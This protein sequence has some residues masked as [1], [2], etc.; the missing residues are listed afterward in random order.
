MEYDRIGGIAAHWTPVLEDLDFGRFSPGPPSLHSE[1]MSTSAAYGHPYGPID[2]D[3][4]H[5][6]SEDLPTTSH[7]ASSRTNTDAAVAK[8]FGQLAGDTDFQHDSP[9]SDIDWVRRRR[10]NSHTQQPETIYSSQ[11]YAWEG[12]QYSAHIAEVGAAIPGT[13]SGRVSKDQVLGSESHPWQSKEALTMNPHEID[14]FDNFVLRISHWLDLFDPMQSFSTHVPHLAMHN[15]GLLNAILSL[16]TCHL[17]LTSRHVNKISLNR[18]D[19]VQYY[20]ETLRYIQDA[21]KH[22]SYNRS[23]ELLSTCLIISAYEMID[24]SHKNW[25]RHLQG[26]YRLQQSPLIHG[27]SRGIKQAVWWAWLCQDIWA[28][29]REKRRPYTSWHPTQDYDNMTPYEL[30]ACSIYLMGQVVSYC[31]QSEIDQGERNFKRRVATA[32][33]LSNTLNE[34]Q[35]HL[36]IEFS[37]L[38]MSSKV[39]SVFTPIWVHPPAFST[40]PDPRHRPVLTDFEGVALQL[41]YAARILL[42]FHRPCLRGIGDFMAQQAV[43]KTYTDTICGLASTLTDDASCIMSSQCLFIGNDIPTSILS[44][45][46]THLC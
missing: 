37:P 34:W 29:F 33:H 32:D 8:W 44:D 16:S 25:E 38:P 21:M 35:R 3:R 31:S 13:S 2:I 5:T 39:D 4:S 23:D 22:D 9:S 41:H 45:Q 42:L 15:V 28:A 11:N 6:G 10:S 43:V 12:R 7:P 40:F 36:P 18:N 30:A 14:I 19:A 46:L 17:S 26:F 27:E 24:G 20:H 1:V